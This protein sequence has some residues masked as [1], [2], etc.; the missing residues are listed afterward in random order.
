MQ[1]DRRFHTIRG[2]DPTGEVHIDQ[3]ASILADFFR[4]V[5]RKHPDW[6][7]ERQLQGAVA[8]YNFGLRNVGTMERLDIG[9]TGNDYSND[10]WARARYYPGCSA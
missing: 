2:D 8:A 7:R 10:V 1:V 6:P 9:T 5:Q 4:G 3:A